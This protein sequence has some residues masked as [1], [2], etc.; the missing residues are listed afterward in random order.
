MSRHRHGGRGH[1]RGSRRDYSGPP[2][3][4]PRGFSQLGVGD[5]HE[6]FLPGFHGP[7]KREYFNKL[8]RGLVSLSG[9][10]GLILGTTT[11]G[12]IGGFLGLGLGLMLASKTAIKDRFYRRGRR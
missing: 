2:R 8:A 7:A 12:P 10:M 3:P 11:L 1:R 6:I 9:L 5:F 4:R